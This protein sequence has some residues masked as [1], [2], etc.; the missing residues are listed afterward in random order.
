MAKAVCFFTQNI[1]TWPHH[2]CLSI[3]LQIRFRLLTYSGW[4]QCAVPGKC[5]VFVCACEVGQLFFF[6]TVLDGHAARAAFAACPKNRNQ[7]LILHM[8]H[9]WHREVEH[10][11]CTDIKVENVPLVDMIASY[12][13]QLPTLP[14]FQNCQPPSHK[15]MTGHRGCPEDARIAKVLDHLTLAQVL[16]NSVCQVSMFFNFVAFVARWCVRLGHLETHVE[17]VAV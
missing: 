7:V 5:I 11:T 4:A 16:D 1:R 10:V 13:L 17:L 9:W 15:K 8:A 6:E 2:P 3:S 12:A 14:V